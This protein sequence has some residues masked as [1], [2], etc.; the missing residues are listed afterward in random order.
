M[1]IEKRILAPQRV[2]HPPRD[3]FSWL[4]RRFVRDYAPSLS[5]E[6]Q[7]LYYFLAAVADKNGLSY[8]KDETLCQR[9]DLDLPVLSQARDA[10]L[11]RD[12]IAWQPPLTQVLSMPIPPPPCPE[13]VSMGTIL[14]RLSEG[15][16]PCK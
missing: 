7:L 10:L 5:R 12:L 8:Y 13:P 16:A 11:H 14:R 9:L 6:A 1:R 4:D 2:R 3:G 15:A